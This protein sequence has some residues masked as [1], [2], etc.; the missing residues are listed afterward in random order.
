MFTATTLS[1]SKPE[2]YAELASQA[3]SL[4]A[5]ERDRIANAAN[6]SALVYHAL[7]ALNW[8][9]FYF[10]DGHELVVGPFQGQPACVRIPLDKGVCGA[11]ATTR[12]TQRVADVDAFPGHIA[13]DSASRSEVVVPLV[14]D[15]RLIGVFDIDSPKLDRFDADDQ[16]GLETIAAVFVDSLA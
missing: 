7:P 2:Q 3:R 11:A 10:H 16:R 15:G 12:K 5:G 6:L 9:G 8:V 4:L 1:G 13:C 14:A